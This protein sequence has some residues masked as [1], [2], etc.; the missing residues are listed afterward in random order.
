MKNDDCADVGV[1]NCDE[2]LEKLYQ[3]LDSELDSATSEGIRAHLDKCGYCSGSFDFEK[4]LKLV[5]KER[6]AEEVPPQFIL[7]LRDALDAEGTR[8]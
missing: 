4:R 1:H 8:I 2:A 5:V 7:R 6:L 3:Y